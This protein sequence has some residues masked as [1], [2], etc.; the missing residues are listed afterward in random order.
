M[1]T[2]VYFLQKFTSVDNLNGWKKVSPIAFYCIFLSEII[3][4]LHVLVLVWQTTVGFAEGDESFERSSKGT[5]LKHK[6]L[7][8]IDGDALPKKYNE[9]E[10]IFRRATSR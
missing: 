8:E 4:S 1:R 3:I 6:S 7:I 2:T 5:S 10:S 9:E